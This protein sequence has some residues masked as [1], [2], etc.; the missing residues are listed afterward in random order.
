M[1]DNKLTELNNH[2]SKIK[3]ELEQMQSDPKNINEDRLM[4]ILDQVTN[5]LDNINITEIID[6][7]D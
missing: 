6:N 4:Q 1:E 7:A 2:L 5:N 3:D